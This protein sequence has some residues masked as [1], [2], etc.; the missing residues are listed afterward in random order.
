M[1]TQPIARTIRTLVPSI[2]ALRDCPICGGC[3]YTSIESVTNGRHLVTVDCPCRTREVPAVCQDCG[4]PA[5]GEFMYLGH[6]RCAACE[7][8]DR[9][10]NWAEAQE[11]RRLGI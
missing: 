6:P 11:Y 2:E 4:K 5:G 8:Y 7:D 9:Y 1:S 3:G 10:R